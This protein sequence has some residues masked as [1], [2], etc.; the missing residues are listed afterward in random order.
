MLDGYD[1]T[2][3]DLPEPPD[4]EAS[5]ELVARIQ[6]GDRAAG[7]ELYRR[8]RDELLFAIRARLGGRLRGVL[9]SEDVLQSVALEA[10][11]GLP[12]FEHRGPGSLRGWL[13]RI[14]VNKVSDLADRWNAQKRDG[15]RERGES[16][17]A[18]VP[19]R[20]GPEPAYHDERYLRLERALALLPADQREV[21][22]LRRVEG[23]T[24]REAAERLA[25]S[26]AAGRQLYSRGLARLALHMGAE[27]Q[28]P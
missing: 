6:A 21:L 1:R 13:Q 4:D 17:L 9:Q 20:A 26:D 15:G 18:E 2:V 3:D 25:C 28:A 23:L 12:R 22:I 5:R 24:S 8:Y 27:R 19:E 11:R 14:L 16:A 7:D 10:L